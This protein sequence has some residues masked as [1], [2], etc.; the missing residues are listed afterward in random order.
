MII[1]EVQSLIYSLLG[2]IFEANYL[3]FQL[4][5]LLVRD[6]FTYWLS[7][8]NDKGADFFQ[9]IEKLRILQFIS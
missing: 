7:A 3:A 2:V 1:I 9:F 6:R 8:E 4:Y 5:F